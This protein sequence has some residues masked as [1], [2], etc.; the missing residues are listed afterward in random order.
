[1]SQ[2]QILLSNYPEHEILDNAV[3][4]KPFEAVVLYRKGEQDE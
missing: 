4:L 2:Y 1:M 3:W